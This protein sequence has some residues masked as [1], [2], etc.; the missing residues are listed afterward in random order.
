MK[1]I[2]ELP[3]IVLFVILLVSCNQTQNISIKE[4]WARPGTAGS[5]SAVYFIIDNPTSQA[6]SLVSASSEVAVH[7]EIHTTMHNEHGTAMMRPLDS[8]E[9]PAKSLVEFVPGGLHVMLIGLVDDLQI[10]DQISISLTFDDN[11]AMDV[12]AV[13]ADR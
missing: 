12:D 10:G 11:G 4:A 8:V 7:V 13:V 3:S 5:N 2:F 9:I 6:I 1:R